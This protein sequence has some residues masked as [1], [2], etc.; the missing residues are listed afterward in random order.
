MM[1][2]AP[3]HEKEGCGIQKKREHLIEHPRERIVTERGRQHQKLRK[4]VVVEKGKEHPRE[5][6][7]GEWL[8]GGGTKTE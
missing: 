4:M 7:I 6:G 5:R 2:R 3:K 1:K 8:R